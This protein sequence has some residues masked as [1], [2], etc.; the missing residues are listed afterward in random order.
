MAGLEEA[1]RIVYLGEKGDAL[2]R[3]LPAS[4]G[5]VVLDPKT[6]LEEILLNLGFPPA[7]LDAVNASGL[8][9]ELE[10]LHAA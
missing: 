4:M 6:G 1:D 8:E 3:F 2:R 7:V 5:M 9:E 10:R